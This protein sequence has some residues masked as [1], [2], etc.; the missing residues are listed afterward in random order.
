MRD[1][2]LAYCFTMFGQSF[3]HGPVLDIGDKCKF[4]FEHDD[5][6]E[7]TYT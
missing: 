7:H 3:Y 1:E 2:F 5:V 6:S 4:F